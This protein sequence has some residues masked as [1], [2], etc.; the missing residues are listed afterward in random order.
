MPTQDKKQPLI[1]GGKILEGK[2]AII[3][4]AGQGIGHGI[5]LGLAEKGASIVA[6]DMNYEA[7]QNLVSV[8]KRNNQKALAIKADVSMA[9]EVNA[10]VR[11]V[12]DYF[13]HIDI[14][15][16]NAGIS[17]LVP[18]V[19][20]TEEQWDKTMNVNLKGMLF[21]CQEVGRQMIKERK[22]TII[23]IAS[24]GG[25]GGIP[26]MAAYCASKGAVLSLTRSLAIEW[27]EYNIRV[28]SISPGMTET[29]LVQ[30]LRTQ[31]PETFK[32]REKRIPLGRAGQVKD[33][34]SLVIFL[35]SKESDYITGQD[36]VIDGGLF[37]I[38]PG[39][40]EG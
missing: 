2:I 17:L 14:L 20:M 10:A 11:E 22:G 33:V 12:L 8:L 3:T 26:K 36:V 24:V 9:T 28:N 40:V 4:G 37:A 1:R 21:C 30:N 13:H 7:V 6:I 31:S 29:S 16:N 19:Q 25:H 38:H 27:A 39:Y 18:T 5:A 23:N 35:A 15:V 32:K 34:V